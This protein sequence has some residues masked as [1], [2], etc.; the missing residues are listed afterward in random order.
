VLNGAD[1]RRYRKTIRLTQVEFAERMGVS[2]SAL[3]LLE[4]GRIAVSE[5][6]VGQLRQQFGGREFKPSFPK[7]LEDL[8]V[9]RKAAQAALTTATGRYLTLTVWRWEDGFDLSHPPGPECA[10]N[11]VTVRATDLPTIA[12]QMPRASTHWAKNEI[13][14]FEECQPDELAD[15]DICL[16]QVA[17][18]R[19]RVP[20][21]TIGLAQLG[22]TSNSPSTITPL[23]GRG[24]VMRADSESVRALLRVSFRAR[25]V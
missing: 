19:S 18:S 25:E 6:H 10:V 24:S 9:S 12:F 15:G 20:R 8:E 22:A 5:D 14:V 7:F 4:S 17:T 3:S 23:K 16:L 13:L 11:V 21:T 1:I 2:Q